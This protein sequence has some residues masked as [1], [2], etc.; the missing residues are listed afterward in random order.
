MTD[1][2]GSSWTLEEEKLL[3]K[4]TGDG[5]PIAQIALAHGR[6]VGGIRARQKRL[7]L[8]DAAGALVFPLPEFKS[9]L[10]A[11]PQRRTRSGAPPAME[12][13]PRQ[14]PAGTSVSSARQA[15]AGT[16]SNHGEAAPNP[17][18]PDN[19]PS[20]R[21]WV[22]MLWHAICH[23]I[24]TLPNQKRPDEII[25]R[26][27][28]IALARL[29]PGEEFHPTTTRA[30]LAERYGVVRE[31]IRQIETKAL[32]R[33]QADIRRGRAV[34]ALALSKIAE[35]APEDQSDV[36]SAWFAAEL[37][38]QN[39]SRFFT[40]FALTAFLATVEKKPQ[41]EIPRLVARALAAIRQIR[42][43]E[44]SAARRNSAQDTLAKP[45][46]RANDFI[47]GIL[48]RAVW[49]RHLNSKPV[50]LSGFPPLRVCNY[51]RQY[52]SE[53]LQ[54]LVGF[55]SRGEQRVIRALDICTVVAEF[56]EQPLG[57]KYEYN[58]R[59]RTYIPDLLLKTDMDLVFVIEVKARFQLAD[60]RTLAKAKAAEHYLG[61][62]GIGY[63][64]VDQDGFGLDDLRA[65]TPDQKIVDL[66]GELL[67]HKKVVTWRDFEQA[68]GSKLPQSAYDQLQNAV[69][70]F[71]M[72]YETRLIQNPNAP[73][74]YVFNFRLR[75]S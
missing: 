12:V 73:S 50:D 60:H 21:N 66:L 62:R 49:P 51:E 61:S 14:K 40:E 52:Y 59:E 1:Q 65:L 43:N 69:L 9:Y 45:V 30:Q 23:D 22:E 13:L 44:Q 35:S 16:S 57:I 67:A 17:V 41:K 64:L 24:A 39:C 29:S 6:T 34:S 75:S 15:L 37:A 27:A 48:Q 68:Y 63:C 28:V 58:G 32:R 72:R 8:R 56:T 5:V 42:R 55:D 38:R 33:L 54:R 18:W 11:Q 26:E 70:R 36:V 74:G 71:D 19:F 20:T 31:R 25:K 46:Q 7:E 2:A 10:L 3:Y 47:L 53:T 4:E